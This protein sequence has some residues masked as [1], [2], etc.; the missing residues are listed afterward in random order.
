MAFRSIATAL[1]LFLAVVPASF[2]QDASRTLDVPADKKWQHATT[3]L[4]VPTTLAGLPR[5]EITDASAS[6]L[7][8]SVQFGTVDTTFATVFLFRPALMSVP[9]W[10]DRV[11]TQVLKGTTFGSAVPIEQPAA[12]ALPGRTVTSALR[13]VYRAGQPPFT[14]TGIAVLPL[15][16][17]LVVLRMSSRVLSPADLDSKIGAAVAGLGWP[18]PESG[19]SEAM[20]ATVVQPCATPL[21]YDAKAKM[22][23][24][25][26]AQGL[27]GATLAMMADKPPEPGV[28]EDETKPVTFCR[29][30]EPTRELAVYRATPG[31]AQSYTIAL[32]DAGRTVSVYP[33]LL[34]DPKKP[35]FAV[36]LNTLDHAYV[37]PSFNRLPAPGKVMEAIG[38]TQP[39]ASS[40]SGGSIN[41]SIR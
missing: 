15:G 20:P 35:S 1:G 38:K 26:L 18:A 4:I 11:E 32:A 27:I 21:L 16:K 24:P 33:D 2:A 13:R 19:A 17:W 41:V 37:F 9:I 22:K 14:A 40:E 25:D 3:G 7:D 12:F 28:Q 23:K 34:S 36:T 29:D 8:V 6:E 10:F 5:T 39:I 31:D 30:G